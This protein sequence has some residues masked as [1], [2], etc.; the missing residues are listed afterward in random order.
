[1]NNWKDCAIHSLHHIYVYVIRSPAFP[2]LFLGDSC[3][4]SKDIRDECYSASADMILVGKAILENV[5][6]RSYPKLKMHIFRFIRTCDLHLWKTRW[7]LGGMAIR[8]HRRWP[9][10][11]L[12][13][14]QEPSRP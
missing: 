5:E 7:L 4:L 2:F 10:T 3:P 6:Y 1:M 11:G 14:R 12:L 8:H 9:P 13:A